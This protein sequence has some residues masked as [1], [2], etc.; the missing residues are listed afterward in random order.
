MKSK[1]RRQDEESKGGGREE[2]KEKE[3]AREKEKSEEGMRK[4]NR[5]GKMQMREMV[6]KEERSEGVKGKYRERRR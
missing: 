6:E 2:G 3:E 1:G 5:D 4:W